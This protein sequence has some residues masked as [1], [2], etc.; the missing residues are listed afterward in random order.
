LLA[1]SQLRNVWRIVKEEIRNVRYSMEPATRVL[2]QEELLPGELAEGEYTRVEEDGAELR[3]RVYRDM[4]DGQF[5]GALEIPGR[6]KFTVEPKLFKN[7]PKKEAN[8]G[9]ADEMSARSKKR[10]EFRDFASGMIAGKV[11]GEDEVPDEKTREVIAEALSMDLKYEAFDV[12]RVDRR[13]DGSPAY[14]RCLNSKAAKL[15]EP[16]AIHVVEGSFSIKIN[17]SSTFAL[18]VKFIPSKIIYWGESEFSTR[19]TVGQAYD[20]IA[21]QTAQEDNEWAKFSAKVASEGAST[22]GLLVAPRPRLA[23]KAAPEVEEMD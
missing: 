20:E 17:A 7:V 8:G 21:Q 4:K 13:P 23:I 14:T 10:Q 2:K 22:G 5:R 9:P 3:L 12:V 15:A 19:L 11:E 1:L 6:V 16:D 18:T